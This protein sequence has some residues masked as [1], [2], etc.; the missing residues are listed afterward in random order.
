MD[1]CIFYLGFI[2][3]CHLHQDGKQTD[4]LLSSKHY[5]SGLPLGVREA[6]NTYTITI[7]TSV[8]TLLNF[9]GVLLYWN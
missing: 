3:G 9:P 5:H 1:T 7:Y 4:D 2:H 8:V 6:D